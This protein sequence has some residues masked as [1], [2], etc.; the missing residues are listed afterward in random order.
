[1]DSNKIPANLISDVH[2]MIDKNM[3]EN[4]LPNAKIKTGIIDTGSSLM[5]TPNVEDIDKET[6]KT[7]AKT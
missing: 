1:M 6:L 2:Q 7:S 5:C 3:I 4:I